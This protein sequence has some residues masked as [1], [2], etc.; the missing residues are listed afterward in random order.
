MDYRAP[1][2]LLNRKTFFT[3]LLLV[4]FLAA[5]GNSSNSSSQHNVV[6]DPKEVVDTLPLSEQVDQYLADNFS[7]S[8]AGIAV[9]VAEGEN[10]IYQGQAGLA[11]KAE[12]LTV[13]QD[14][15]FRLASVSKPFTAIAVFILIEQ[16]KLTLSDSILTYLPELDPSW[17]QVTIASLLSHQ[18][19]I[20][21]FFTDEFISALGWDWLEGLDNQRVL[22]YFINHPELE[23]SPNSQAQY[24]NTNFSL[25]ATIIERVSGKSFSHFMTEQLFSPLALANSYVIDQG[26]EHLVNEALNYGES[27]L[28]YGTELYIN[29]ASG[30]VSSANDLWR[31]LNALIAQ[32]IISEYSLDLMLSI[33]ST[34]SDGSHYGFGWGVDEMTQ[35]NQ[36]YVFHDGSNDG[37]KSQ[38]AL[39]KDSG[40]MV[41]ILSN[42]GDSAEDKVAGILALIVNH[43]QLD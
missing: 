38:I 25:L 7:A 19:G 39:V 28:M 34:F 3:N 15:P 12:N 21:N 9:L 35:S 36:L 29:G 33:Q 16:G 5:C 4:L 27:Y 18:S 11:N 22:E 13:D 17:K 14:T 6:I 1:D 42:A 41:I 24:S 2:V 23:F 26:T 8:D 43:Y 20:P 37:F 31:L 40:L 30:Q 32:Q 10:K